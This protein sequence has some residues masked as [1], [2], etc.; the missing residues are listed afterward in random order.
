[1][2]EGTSTITALTIDAGTFRWDGVSGTITTANIY[3][4][5]VFAQY[6]GNITNLN[7]AGAF[8][9]SQSVVTRTVTNAQI[10]RGGTFLDPQKQ[11][12][13]TNGLD[14]YQCGLQDVTLD[15]GRHRTVTPSAI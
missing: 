5:T 8:D 4:G 14:V 2:F 7:I 9:A 6:G 15:I 13:I 12:T 3:G 10:T 11:V 1:M